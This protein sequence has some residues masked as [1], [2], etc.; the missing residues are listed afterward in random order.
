MAS[1]IDANDGGTNSTRKFLCSCLKFRTR[2]SLKLILLGLMVSVMSTDGAS[3][4]NLVVSFSIITVLTGTLELD[5]FNW[6]ML[7]A[8]PMVELQLSSH[9]CLTLGSLVWIMWSCSSDDCFIKCCF[10]GE[11]SFKFQFWGILENT[12]PNFDSKDDLQQLPYNFSLSVMTLAVK[13]LLF[14]ASLFHT[15]VPLTHLF[16]WELY[17]WILDLYILVTSTTDFKYFHY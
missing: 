16:K 7:F 2:L 10:F 11:C 5:C 13:C 4:Q 9:I 6:T 15:H 1:M 12:L 14:L 17:V 8:F 3:N